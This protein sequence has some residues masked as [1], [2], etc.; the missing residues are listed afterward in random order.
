MRRY[1]GVLRLPGAHVLLIVGV[2]ARLGI[3][4]TP[5]ALLLVIADATGDYASAG[6]AGGL[7]ALAAA[8]MAPIAGR[9]ADR[10][11]PAPVLIATSVVHPAAL[12]ALVVATGHLHA[13]VSPVAVWSCAALAG[14]TY[15]PLTA[16]IRGAWNQLA[17]GDPILRGDAF[18]LE[19]S[20]FEMVFVIG[21]LL[22]AAFVAFASARTAIFAAAGLTFFGTI[23]VARGKAIR[24][25]K[26]HPHDARTTGL[27]PLRTS[28]FRVLLGCAAGLGCSFGVVGVAVPAYATSAHV[29]N[30]DG[31]AGVLLA[32]W[33]IGSAIGGITFGLRRPP[34]RPV[35]QLGWLLLGVGVSI[36]ALALAPSTLTLGILLAVGGAT[37][38]PALTVLNSL[39]GLVTPASMHNEAYTW[40]TTL[41]V[42]LSAGGG[43]AAGLIVDTSAGSRWAFAGAGL[44]VALSAAASTLPSLTGAVTG[45]PSQADPS[46]GTPSRL[47]VSDSS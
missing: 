47:L 14:A 18:T 9:I 23:T 42:A 27:G 6:V 26:R 45:P 22:V 16:A 46:S 30:P 40:M 37:I 36:A 24:S 31:L 11:G 44:A 34:L 19:T 4:I 41:T 15:P 8:I 12:V 2:I 10:V 20:L 43:A 21:P 33:G 5:L 28:G 3:G 1:G 13:G 7:Y 32:L 35:R 29:S 39:V 17:S 38:A 25:T